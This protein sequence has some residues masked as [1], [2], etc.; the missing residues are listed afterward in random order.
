MFFPPGAR[1][2]ALPTWRNPRLYL[3]TRSVTQRWTQSVLYPA[4]RPAARIYRLALRL[5]AA[6]GVAR[7][8]TVPA[9]D[10]PL[11][12]FAKN[13]YPRLASTVVLVGTAGPTQHVTVQLRDDAGQV[14]GYLKYA[15]KDRAQTRL[16]HEHFMLSNVPA[17]VAPAPLK[18]GPLGSGEALIK[19]P[20]PGYPLLA[21]FLPAEELTGLLDSLGVSPPVPLEE[22]PWVRKHARGCVPEAWL[23][24]LANRN[25][26]VVVQHGDFTPWNLIQGPDGKLRAV[27]WEYGALEGFPGLDLAHYV[28]QT[29][30]LVHRRKPAEAVRYAVDY[31]LRQSPPPLT[32]VEAQAVIR[33]AAH[34]AYQK[35]L[36]D[37]RP[38][39]S[40]LQL[41]RRAVCELP[42]AV[43]GQKN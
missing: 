4:S 13:L 31:L 42:L 14:L 33:L 19:S 36:R 22:H 16:R 21:T 18:L 32:R 6:A 2:L 1:V 27:D 41:W 43:P 26:P 3:P 37:G 24:V 12:A 25:W 17:D 40:K 34:D 15:E 7:V 11:W 8:R 23:E 20:L 35:A 30:A 28:L 39:A 38:P 9:G 29:S 5:K 10:W